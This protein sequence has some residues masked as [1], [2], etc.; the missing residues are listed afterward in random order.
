MA[1]I[2]SWFDSTCSVCCSSKDEHDTAGDPLYGGNPPIDGKSEEIS[3]EVQ[4][5]PT[6]EIEGSQAKYTGQWLG[7]VRHGYGFMERADGGT[8]KKN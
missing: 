3:G 7:K 4:D 6:V 2:F 5:R 8:L 1:S